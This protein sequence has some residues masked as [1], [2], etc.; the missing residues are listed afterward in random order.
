MRF[1]IREMRMI[2]FFLPLKSGILK[3][4]VNDIVRAG[5]DGLLAVALFFGAA[6]RRV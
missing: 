2:R 4:E 6:A 1:F 3:K 5:C